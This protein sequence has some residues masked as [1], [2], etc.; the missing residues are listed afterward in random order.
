MQTLRHCSFI[1]YLVSQTLTKQKFQPMVS[2]LI[3]L[4]KMVPKMGQTK[5]Y[6]RAVLFTLI[7]KIKAS[8]VIFNS[9]NFK[10]I[11]YLIICMHLRCKTS[12][13]KQYLC[14]SWYEQR[15][16]SIYS[17]NTRPVRYHK[18]YHITC[19]TVVVQIIYNF[20]HTQF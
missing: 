18:L 7:H 15:Y 9:M 1:V 8:N 4:L 17:T 19:T 16:I 6:Y 3:C 11:T 13:H 5:V 10:I 12:S 2:C 20:A 14:H